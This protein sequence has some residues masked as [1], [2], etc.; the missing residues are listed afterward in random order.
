[1]RSN[2]RHAL[3]PSHPPAPNALD[4]RRDV[5][6]VRFVPPTNVLGRRSIPYHILLFGHHI[7]HNGT[8]YL[9]QNDSHA[10][11]RRTTLSCSDAASRRASRS[12]T[13]EESQE[14]WYVNNYAAYSCRFCLSLLTVPHFPRRTGVHMMLLS[15]RSPHTYI[16]RSECS[17]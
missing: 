9:I 16:T 3:S 1:M 5:C 14:E 13:S 10:M 11:S 4:M 7:S 2:A 8:S 6:G 15:H 12:S 17:D